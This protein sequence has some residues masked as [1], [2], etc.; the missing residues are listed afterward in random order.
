MYIYEYI[1]HSNILNLSI[2]V[3]QCYINIFIYYIDYSN[4]YIDE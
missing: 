4:S 2:Y 1:G 3:Y